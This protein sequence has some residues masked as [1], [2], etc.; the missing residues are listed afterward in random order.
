MLLAQG[1]RPIIA[2]LNKLG[3]NLVTQLWIIN[4]TNSNKK[5]NK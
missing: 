1:K 4:Y 5:Q 3:Q 2:K